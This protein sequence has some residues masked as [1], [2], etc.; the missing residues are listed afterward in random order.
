MFRL[1]YERYN[2]TKWPQYTGSDENLA[3]LH[4]LAGLVLSKKLVLPCSSWAFWAGFLSNA[5]E[6]HVNAP[7]LHQ[8]LPASNYIYHH[9]KARL[10]YGR[11]NHTSGDI[12]YAIDVNAREAAASQ[13]PA[14]QPKRRLSRR[15]RA[16][17]ARTLLPQRP[18]QTDL[19]DY[20]LD[21]HPERLA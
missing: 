13:S 5:S 7:P 10:Y 17:L 15:E 6:V 12:D 19:D 16:A 3:L 9:E 20:L 1:L 11:F 18:G 21:I 8:V 4:D 2:A 14:Q